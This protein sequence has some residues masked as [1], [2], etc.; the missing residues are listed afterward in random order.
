MD[1]AST[2]TTPTPQSPDLDVHPRARIVAAVERVVVFGASALLA[3]AVVQLVWSRVPGHLDVSTDIVG[4]PTVSGF[5]SRRNEWGY[6]LLVVVLP[7]ALLGIYAVAQRLWTLLSRGTTRREWLPLPPPTPA[8]N[9]TAESFGIPGVAWKTTVVACARAALVATVFALEIA[10]MV[11]TSTIWQL[12][13]A[14]IVGYVA[15]LAVVALL[16]GRDG[17]GW[18]TTMSIINALAMPLA[19]L[20]LWGVSRATRVVVTEDGT[21]H[22]YG[23]MPAA[24]ALVGAA[25]AWILVVRSLHAGRDHARSTERRALVYVVGPILVF[26]LVAFLPGALGP[27]N[28][29]E[30]GQWLGGARLLLDGNLPYRDFVAIHGPLQDVLIAAL[31]IQVIQSS[32]WGMVAG[33]TLLVFPLYWV[34]MY[35]LHAYLFGRN[36]YFLAGTVLVTIAGTTLFAGVMQSVHVR[37]LVPLLLLAV[38]GV[39]SH[40][41]RIRVY[42]LV[43]VAIVLVYVTPEMALAI[44]GVVITVVLFDYHYRVPR[45]GFTTV[46]R[47]TMLCCEAALICGAIALALL[48]AASSLGAVV[49]HFTTFS[50]GHSLTGSFPIPPETATIRSVRYLIPVLVVV[51]FWFFVSRLRGR[52]RMELADWVM[53]PAVIL[54]ALYYPKFLGRPDDG[55]L[56]SVWAIAI[57]LVYYVA[58]RVV[59]GCERAASRTRVGDGLARLSTPHLLTIAVVFAVV[60][61]GGPAISDVVTGTTGRF[62]AAAEAEPTVDVVGYSSW[63]YAPLLHDIHT[64]VQSIT[65]RN[66]QVFDFTNAPG[67][68]YYT[69][70]YDPPTRYYHVSTAIRDVTQQDLVHELRSA[71]PKV[72]TYDGGDGLNSWDGIPNSVRHYD[73]SAYLLAH[74]RPIARVDGISFLLRDDVALPVGWFASLDLRGKATEADVYGTTGACPWGR[75]ADVSDRLPPRHPKYLRELHV[76]DT[77][78]E[79]GQLTQVLDRPAEATRGR[80]LEIVADGGF[81]PDSFTL[82]E[83]G[84]PNRAITFD[85]DP[86]S[87]HRYYVDVGACPQW[88]AYRGGTLLLQHAAAQRISSIKLLG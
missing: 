38:A 13:L 77:T 18:S 26:L 59:T 64:V 66:D 2:T 5:D 52:H 54:V 33:L 45:A 82:S 9:G 47:R 85:T 29:F 83:T 81:A 70:G 6:Y 76:A 14:T 22:H 74:Y 39:L 63:N 1:T 34:G 51:S 43:T 36:A 40:P 46:F 50:N 35:Y 23:W 10:V 88:W 31:G 49:E 79:H 30:H 20:G 61:A 32:F 73:V 17:R 57:P 56:L 71:R 87:P 7:L 3:A 60:V 75:F 42:A 37:M 58:Y 41:S 84:D 25:V 15:L 11:H 80:W 55:H 44:P 28:A 67:L 8:G 78:E 12:L 21:V 27:M 53:L 69:A 62:D 48:V 19:I 68:F 24:L 4:Y 72:V 86:R 65:D 16:V